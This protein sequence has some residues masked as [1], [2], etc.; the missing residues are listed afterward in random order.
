MVYTRVTTV[1]IVAAVLVASAAVA[2][3]GGGVLDRASTTMDAPGDGNSDSGDGTSAVDGPAANAIHHP[4]DCR[5]GTSGTILACGFNPGPTSVAIQRGSSPLSIGSTADGSLVV[6]IRAVELSTGGFI[7]VHRQ[8]IFDGVVTESVLGTSAYL[9]PGLHRNVTVELEGS[10]AVGQSLVAVVY[11]DTDG[12]QQYDFVATAGDDDRPYTNSYD[13]RTG[14][15]TDDAGRIIG[16]V[17]I[18]RATATRDVV[19]QAR[20]GETVRVTTTVRVARETDRVAIQDHFSPALGD[21]TMENVRFLRG[22][23]TVQLARTNSEN[24]L[25]AIADV[26][27][28]SVIEVSYTIT[29]PETATDG[30]RFTLSGRA[31][32]SNA[33][34]EP[35]ANRTITVSTAGEYAGPDGVV[36]LSELQDAVED[37]AS[38]EITISV[39]QRVVEAWA[40]GG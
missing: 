6:T 4:V 36:D 40:A 32:R 35:V 1:V 29:I 22:D 20:P 28:G 26:S 9:S 17:A 8:S 24:S 15:V 38:G 27:A 18:V 2:L 16:D 11:R 37:W 39:L 31:V 19:S 14:N 12:D 21:G 30:T 33:P 25:V 10:P 5:N 3:G 34:D 13:D 23:G 7:A